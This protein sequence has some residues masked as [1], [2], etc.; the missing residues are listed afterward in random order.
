M[1]MEPSPIQSYHSWVGITAEGAGMKIA[2]AVEKGTNEH[3]TQLPILARGDGNRMIVPAVSP[4]TGV[5]KAIVH[6]GLRKKRR[7]VFR[8]DIFANFHDVVFGA[9]VAM[10]TEGPSKW[11]GCEVDH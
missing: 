3:L 10:D 6:V 7:R 8:F 9:N 5:K 1:S 11:N 4:S 2:Y